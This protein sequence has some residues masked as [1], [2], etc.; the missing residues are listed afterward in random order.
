MVGYV[1]IVVEVIGKYTVMCEMIDPTTNCED[2]YFYATEMQRIM[3]VRAAEMNQP[4]ED[5]YCGIVTDNALY[6]RC[7]CVCVGVCH[8]VCVCARACVYM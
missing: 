8:S 2:A 3:H 1:V 4:V 5:V 6:H 7:V